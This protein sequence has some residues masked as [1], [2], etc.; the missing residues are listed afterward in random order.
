[1]ELIEDIA[2]VVIIVDDW[3]W[4]RVFC[5]S[6]RIKEKTFLIETHKH[7]SVNLLVFDFADKCFVDVRVVV[8]A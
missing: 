1:M 4:I 2:G 5:T 8:D 3:D 7:G 6:E